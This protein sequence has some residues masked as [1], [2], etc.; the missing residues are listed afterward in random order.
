MPYVTSWER[1]S[2]EKGIT[3]GI[4]QSRR[5]AVLEILETRLG[6]VPDSIVATINQIEDT[7]LLKT[8]H[9][10]AITIGFHAEFETLCQ[11]LLAGGESS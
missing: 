9:K 1:F 4:I 8:L 7:D 11:Q 10:R 3:A 2:I 5:E 6:T